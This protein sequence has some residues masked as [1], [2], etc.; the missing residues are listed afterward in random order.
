MRKPILF[1]FRRAPGCATARMLYLRSACLQQLRFGHTLPPG[2]NDAARSAALASETKATRGEASRSPSLV[3][4]SVGRAPGVACS[5]AHE[6]G[7][8]G[9]LRL[10][11]S[12]PSGLIEEATMEGPRDEVMA[13]SHAGDCAGDCAEAK[14]LVL[15]EG[16]EQAGGNNVNGTS[17]ADEKESEVRVLVRD[18]MRKIVD[19][20]RLHSFAQLRSKLPRW[21]F[22][23]IQ[24][25]GYIKPTLVQSVA[26]PL[27]MERRDVV[28]IAP[29]GSG[30]TVAF[31]LPA[32]A[33]LPPSDSRGNHERNRGNADNPVVVS[34]NVLVLCPT[35][36]LVQ[37]TRNVISQLAG[38]A[39]RVKGAFGGQGREQQMEQ[40]RRWGGCDVLVSTPGRLC[41]F[42]EADVVSLEHVGFLILDEADRML[43]LGFA[44]Q[45]EFIMSTIRK[46]RRP[47]QTTMW[48]ATWNAT[49]GSL[50]SRFLKPE[51]VFFEVDREHKMNTDITQ[52]LYPLKDPSQ[53]IHAIVKLY[54]NAI[55]SKRQQVL[56]FVNRKEDVEQL[57]ED[58]KTALRAPPDLIRCLHGGM[59]QNKRERILHGFREGN[60]RVL[61]A[62]D[63]V[64]RGLDVPELDHVINYDLPGDSDAY[65]HRVG[66]T[67]RAGRRGT[68]HTFILAGDN[69]APLIARFIAKQQGTALP[70]DVLAIIHDIELHGGA[71]T[72]RPKYKDHARL[73]GKDWRVYGS[74]KSIKTEERRYVR[75]YGHVL[76]LKRPT[77]RKEK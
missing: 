33:A 73:A 24:Q 27:F 40:L 2:L 7:T 45:L 8:F 67:G 54:E 60:I 30:K 36:E 4:K 35:R 55:I 32:L 76:T 74:A 51:R 14:K 50:A 12:G 17:H 13:P 20:K 31:A 75:G 9:S 57:S 18:H 22:Y 39:V 1:S 72:E 16:V 53:R 46:F 58:L 37:Q 23:G 25:S 28:G 15:E 62:T 52:N 3:A 68:A 42:V 38:N 59:K 65:V 71:A 47:R 6:D 41:D 5:A 63:V 61:C 34:P 29:T 26:I 66:R 10:S 77:P 44:P 64:A 49:V 48:T 21:L 19:V 56:I 69:R 70:E 11:S 43:E